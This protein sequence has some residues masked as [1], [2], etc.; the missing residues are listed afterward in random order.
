MPLIR[1]AAKALL[2]S[3][4]NANPAAS[5]ATADVFVRYMGTERRPGESG[6]WKASG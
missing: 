4:S 2:S 3:W 5:V 6:A 1:H